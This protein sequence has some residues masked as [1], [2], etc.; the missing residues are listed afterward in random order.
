[1]SQSVARLRVID[2]KTLLGHFGQYKMNHTKL[3]TLIKDFK[4]TEGH[5]LEV[6]GVVVVPE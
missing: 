2:G 4:L 6:L 1:M 3:E 5:A